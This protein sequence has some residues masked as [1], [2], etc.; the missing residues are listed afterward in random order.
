MAVW[1]RAKLA[2]ASALRVDVLKGSNPFA[3]TN[4]HVTV[5]T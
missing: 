5:E 2:E 1:T 3:A 4:F